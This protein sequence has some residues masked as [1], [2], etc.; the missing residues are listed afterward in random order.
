MRFPL[1]GRSVYPLLSLAAAALAWF[2][3]SRL[4]AWPD[5]SGSGRARP[6][7]YEPAARLV[8]GY[9]PD[10]RPGR[11]PADGHRGPRPRRAAQPRPA[12]RRGRTAGY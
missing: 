5:R 6:A 8:G 3:A 12:L 2:G 4:E 10:H 11:D 1:P 7:A 9:E